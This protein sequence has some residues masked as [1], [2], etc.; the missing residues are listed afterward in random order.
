VHVSLVLLDIDLDDAQASKVAAVLALNAA[1]L[2]SRLQN[3]WTELTVFRAELSTN[4]RPRLTLRSHQ[5]HLQASAF[6]FDR[7]RDA[8]K[9]LVDLK[10]YG[11]G[12]QGSFGLELHPT[13]ERGVQNLYDRVTESLARIEQA[14]EVVT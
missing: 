4:V 3:S 1:G 9:T 11:V 2:R 8:A 10:F 12:R 5:Q 14:A 6:L 7:G 13:R